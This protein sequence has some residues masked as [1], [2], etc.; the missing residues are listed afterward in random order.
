LLP[1]VC[2]LFFVACLPVACCLLLAAEFP[3]ALSRL[4]PFV[5][6]GLPACCL[7][8][9]ACCRISFRPFA[10]SSFR[11]FFSFLLLFHEIDDIIMGISGDDFAHLSHYLMK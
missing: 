1:V 9:V 2:C 5:L 7:L 10:L 8:P 3:F 4:R 6:R 11:P